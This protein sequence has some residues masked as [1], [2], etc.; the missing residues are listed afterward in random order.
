MRKRRRRKKKGEMQL[1][2]KKEWKR[3]L[4]GHMGR[5]RQTGQDLCVVEKDTCTHVTLQAAS[6]QTAD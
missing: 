5:D 6:A 4:K 1:R 2:L 3:M